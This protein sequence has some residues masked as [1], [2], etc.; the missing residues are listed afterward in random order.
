MANKN[1]TSSHHTYILVLLGIFVSLLTLTILT[2]VFKL[3]ENTVYQELI[4]GFTCLGFVV[5]L[6]ILIAEGV[7]LRFDKTALKITF[8]A[9]LFLYLSFIFSNDGLFFWH[10]IGVQV[11]DIVHRIFQVLS[12]LCSTLL[13]AFIFQFFENCYGGKRFHVYHYPILGALFTLYAI[14]CFH[15]L[16]NAAFFV[17]IAEIVYFAIFDTIY[18]F[19]IRKESNKF[20]GV[21]SNMFVMF[22]CFAMG[23]N[24]YLVLGSCSFMYFTIFMGYVFI[25]A[26]FLVDKTNETYRYE[27]QERLRQLEGKMKVTCFHCFDCFYNDEHLDFPSKKSKEYFALLIVLRGKALTIDKAITYLYPD[28]DIEKAKAS[29]RK[30]ISEIRNYFKTIGYEALTFKRGETYLNITNLECDYYQ[31]IDGEKKYNEEPL[32]PEYDWSLE[33]E[34]QCDGNLTK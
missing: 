27:E 8:F 11:D 6:L 5:L 2:I 23:F 22:I 3:K 29:Y 31:V 13:V 9:T 7:S 24:H 20:S 1:K 26:S 17:L 25:Y 18:Y 12:N 32:M 28:K 14:F 16:N 21:I 4:F 30:I 19:R 33:F 15:G 34:S 10:F